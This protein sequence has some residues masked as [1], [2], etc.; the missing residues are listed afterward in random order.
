MGKFYTNNYSDI[1]LYK[2]KSSS[3]EVMTQMIYVSQMFMTVQ[4]SVMV[5]R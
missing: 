1:N 5:L 2:K 4:V 3:S